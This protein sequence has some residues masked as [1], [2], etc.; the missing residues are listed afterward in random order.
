VSA[1]IVSYLRRLSSD[2]SGQT[3]PTIALMMM[4]LLGLTGTV[5]DVGHLYIS[6]NELQAA[7]NAA[8][9]AGAEALPGTNAVTAAT[10]YSAVSGNLNAHGNLP[11]VSM[12]SGYPQ[13]RCLT[14][15]TNQSIPCVSPG[16]GNAIFV[17]QQAVVPTYF[18]RL[19]GLSSVKLL[20][21]AAAAMRGGVTPPHNVVIILDTT[22]SMNNTDR[23]SDCNTT[24]LSCALSGIRTLL[25]ELSPC[26]SSQSTCGTATNGNVPNS[27]DVVG[28]F[29]FPNVTQST[30]AYDSNCSGKNPTPQGYTFPSAAASSYSPGAST[31]TYRIVDFSSDYRISDTT[32]TLNSLSELTM[33]SGGKS[34]C[35]GM[36]APGG[37]GTYTAAAIY[38]AQAALVAE[39]A[40]NPGSQNV[41][42]FLSDGDVGAT[43]SAMPG[44][45]TTSGIYPSTVNQCRQGVIAAQAATAAG[46]TVYTVAYGAESSGCSTDKVAISPCQTMQESATSAATFF[47][48]YAAT[49]GSSS[50][51][52]SARP[53]TSLNQIFT[54]IAGDFTTSR[55]IPTNLQ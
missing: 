23:S 18:A 5:I 31:A 10:N 7:T 16:N 38:A 14:T 43:S 26:A 9:L 45:S 42:I 3:L 44:A 20:A 32:T 41:I 49:G 46:T 4:S 54:Q 37:E 1:G 8:A 39:K 22:G 53:T 33:A 6:Y 19:F 47:S 15:L 50:C 55:L 48:D 2:E 13:I 24:R 52:S 21:T 30:V 11:G 25:Q 35:P 34:H 12:V 51:V 27:V 17:K 40:A 29:A 36:A 28:L